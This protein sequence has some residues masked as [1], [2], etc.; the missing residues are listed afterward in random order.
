MG[1]AD[2]WIAGAMVFVASQALYAT[3]TQTDRQHKVRV[4]HTPHAIKIWVRCSICMCEAPGMG[5]C[6]AE[7]AAGVA[8]QVHI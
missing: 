3:H 8:G 2:Q 5:A 4:R 7:A 6:C 1:V